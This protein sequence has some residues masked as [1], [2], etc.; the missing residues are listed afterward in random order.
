[1]VTIHGK[2]SYF[3]FILLW[4]SIMTQQTEGAAKELAPHLFTQ[5][6]ENGLSTIVKETPGTHAVTVQI[7]VKA[8]SV[9]EEP[10]EA[11]ITHFIEH[12]IF[13]G[14][15][16]RGAGEIAGA[17]EEVGGQINAYTSYESTVYHATLPARHWSLALDVLT[18]AVLH[19]V[20]DPL[21][22]EREKKVVLEEIRMRHD[23]PAT[24]LFQELMA[25]TF[26]THP[27]KAPVIG[28]PETVSVVTREEILA[29][30]KK[31]YI[32]ENLAVIV[33]G[34]V[35]A[36]QVFSRMQE[37]YAALPPAANGQTALPREKIQQ[38]DRF[39]Q[40]TDDVQQ[41]HM[42]LALPACAFNSPDAPVLDVI[43]H[44]LGG[45]ESSRLFR[46]VL[47]RKKLVFQINAS[48][49]TPHD[50]GLFEIVAVLDPANAQNAMTASLVE[51]FRLV[52]EPVSD[53]ELLRAKRNLESDF[54]FNLE[55]VE[56]QARVLG[57]FQ[58]LTGDPRENRYLDQLRQVSKK[59]VRRVA[60]RYFAPG[61]VTAGLVLPEG[62]PVALDAEKVQ[63]LVL[64]AAKQA[65][66][67]APS[68]LVADSFLPDV[69][70][71]TLDNGITL[72][73]R[74]DATV[75]TVAVRAIF[76]G[77]LRGETAMT[78]GAF[79]FISELLPKGTE[80]LSAHE[81][82][83]QVADMAGEIDG[84][85]G[86]NTFGLK[87]DFLARFFASGLELFR[88]VLLTPAMDE[89]E[90]D[91]IRPQL[92]AQLKQQEDSLP[93]LGFREFSRILFDGHP[94]GLNTLGD[95]KVLTTIT[96]RDLRKIYKEH[97]RPDRLVLAIAG[98]VKAQKVR[99]QIEDLFGSWQAA[100]E[101]SPGFTEEF[102]APS[103]PSAPKIHV[104]PR[105]KEQVHILMG[106]L[107]TTMN[108]PDRYPLE[109]LDTVLSGQSGRLFL[110]L[111]DR[112]S[113]AYSISSFSLLGLDTGA[114]GLYIGTS[115]DKKEA[116]I[117]GLWRELERVR[118]EAVS[119]EELARAKNIIISQYELGLQT[120]G[121]QAM[122]MA[123]HE[124]YGLGQDF[125]R[126]Y[127]DAVNQVDAAAV[128]AAAKKYIRPEHS[129]RVMV[130]QAGTGKQGA[131][132]GNQEAAGKK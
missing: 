48:A 74:E 45:G 51:L 111:R 37:L 24:R 77:G 119:P 94:Y 56:G 71:F 50:P 31:H 52:H 17:I 118:R 110:E 127:I 122:D 93:S 81:L 20:F 101:N 75:P 120:H 49:F 12:M 14:T 21:E 78:N 13:K 69:Y 66:E 106:F 99:K 113:L 129:V 95:E 28:S 19:S 63:A 109:V 100:H 131:G 36:D 46:T 76:P 1:M 123:L 62:F 92:L 9:F 72:L 116:A 61:K 5:K 88:D 107:G 102:L 128:L 87:G 60:A 40:L 130:G 58:F 30:M 54:V 132:N 32:P 68:G 2:S 29:Y 8:G 11:G 38:Q 90:A 84:F 33:V 83:D 3:L 91:K 112:Q 47:D 80:K 7:W 16:I 124:S 97:A 79:A 18:D 86:K 96:V 15:A 10:H 22:V 6:L 4:I 27:Y 23:Q 89:E 65:R 59:E 41:A 117:D 104:V 53:A 103:P 73:V 35:A 55:R 108:S 44:I 115:P 34:D 126:R 67:H 98:D 64:D 105:D 26:Q 57:S 121:A 43:S 42:A 82:A 25:T 85:N 70:H 39:F 125:G 114:F